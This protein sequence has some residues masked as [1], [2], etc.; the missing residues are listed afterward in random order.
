[1]SRHEQTKTAILDRL[2]ELNVDPTNPIS[3]YEIGVPLV[4]AGYTED[5]IFHAL[6]GLIDDRVVELI[7]GNRLRV[8]KLP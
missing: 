6:N 5:E 2:K 7:S 4:S 3:L 8:V 1:M